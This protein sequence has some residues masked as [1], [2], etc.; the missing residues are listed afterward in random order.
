MTYTFTE[1]HTPTCTPTLTPT[2]T[3][4]PTASAS[5]TIT[6][7]PR[8]YPYLLVLEAYNEAG[9]KIKVIAQTAIGSGIDVV[10]LMTGGKETDIF[11]PSEAPLVISIP[12]TDSTEQTGGLF[13]EWDGSAANGGTAGQGDY[14]IKIT[15][16]D[17]Y[18]HINTIIKQVKLMKTEEFVRV[19]IYNSAGELV[20]RL[21]QN[22][23][24]TGA[25]VLEMEDVIMV[26]GGAPPLAIKFSTADYFWWDGKNMQGV[27]AGSGTY[28]AVLEIK[29]KDGFYDIQASKPFT[30]LNTEGAPA[31]EGL[32]AYPNPCVLL[33]GVYLP[34]TIDWQLKQ[35]GRIHIR[36][37]NAAGELVKKLEGSLA[38]AAG[39]QWDCTA[40]NGS[41][42]GSGLYVMVVRA[43]KKD[44]AAEVRTLKLVIINKFQA[45]SIVVN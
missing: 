15:V 6:D 36:I 7:T 40:L 11:N 28:E 19:S 34:V 2:F 27:L 20:E 23:G 17:S 24:I 43:V 5:P 3:G 45:D 16:I 42:A 37:Y 22:T 39:I 13:F 4:T 21:A 18:G 31:L 38:S 44:G 9:E 12:G 8:P 1:T 29:N 14:F 10:L 33:D 26:G 25:P 32:K 41:P 35:Q 30:I